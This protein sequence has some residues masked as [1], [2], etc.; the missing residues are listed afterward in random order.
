M[1]SLLHKKRYKIPRITNGLVIDHLPTER[2]IIEKI[3]TILGLSP[4]D[5][6]MIGSNF[7]SIKTGPKSKNIIKVENF[8]S[9]RF[10]QE[11]QE[12]IAVIC[13]N[14][15]Y[16]TTIW[17]IKNRKKTNRILLTLPDK[18]VNVIKC[19]NTKCITA[20]EGHTVASKIFYVSRK[21]PLEVICHYCSYI[22]VEQQ[23]N[24]L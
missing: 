3:E 8:P 19:I 20:V 2:K 1:N 17:F 7:D 15:I 22:M 24:L 21:D 5:Q 4:D 10:T 23:I 13:R 6:V 11:M 18:I 9:E 12:K 16:P 14:A